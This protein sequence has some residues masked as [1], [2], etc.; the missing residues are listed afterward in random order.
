MYKYEWDIETGGYLLTTNVAGV[1]KELRPVF[2]EELNLLGF[3]D[4][5]WVYPESEKP[6]MWAETRRYIYR[7]ELVAEAVGGGLYTRPETKIYK[8]LTNIQ[9]VNIEEMVEKNRPLMTGLVQ[10]T[11]E[12]I[13]KTYNKYKNK[14]NVIYVAF[15]GG[16]DSL[17]LLDLVQK[18]LPHNEFKVIFGDTS[19]EISDTY[20][21]IDKVKERYSDLDIQTA[22]SHLDAKES[23][24]IFGPPSKTLRWCCAVH[25]S[26]P[27]LLKL[28]E[29]TELSRLK[30]LV[31]DGV[32]AE[33]SNARANYPIESDGTKHI[34]QINCSPILNWTT[35]ELFLYILD[36]KLML[37]DAYRY[38]SNRVG[39][40][41]CPMSSEWRDF[42]TN[43]VYKSDIV[44]FIDKIEHYSK[45]V[46]I[47]DRQ[48]KA[49]IESGGW[50]NRAG[51][52]GIE[53]VPR[54]IIQTNKNITRYIFNH[55]NNIWKEWI[56]TIGILTQDS[57]HKY[58]LEY[59]GRHYE[60][61]VFS[62]ENTIIEV[63]GS[64]NSYEDK[65]FNHCLRSIFNKAAYCIGCKVCMVECPIGALIITD[66][67]VKIT[68]ECTRCE[69]CLE[70]PR[71]CLLAKS[72][73]ITT[74]GTNMSN[75]KGIN[76]YG[77]FGFRKDWLKYLK[78][79]GDTAFWQS[80]KLGPD[81]FDGFRK[82]LID[83]ELCEGYSLNEFGKELIKKDLDNIEIW[84]VITVN[85]AY[86]SVIFN[87]YIS[88]IEFNI[89][90]KKNDYIDMLGDCDDRKKRTWSNALN[91]L[92]NTFVTSP[93]GKELGVGVCKIKG[94]IVDTITR[95]P[96]NNPSP[97]VILYSL[98][99]FA[100]KCDGYY[101]FTLSYLCD[102]SIE[103]NGISPST[104]F[105]IGKDIL[106]AKIQN[107][108]TDY[109]DF[110]SATFSKD[111]DNIDLN[112]EKTSLDVLKLF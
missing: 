48:L 13:Y 59:N 32:R 55:K 10:N 23:W 81:Q 6:L 92:L 8:T 9:P 2:H 103:R 11:V 42:I 58:L 14:V 80:G 78:E 104:I 45:N 50:R 69:K 41:L 105:G 85:L 63:V 49:Y 3:K 12:T 54:V 39:C 82:W 61:S 60:F 83:A 107:L 74:G 57:E 111:L 91:S 22:K 43:E 67:G 93:I 17:V 28:R 75:L 46:G 40:V 33:E 18:A 64:E 29:I 108:A 72:L 77:T 79:L 106:K 62:N 65:R 24:D 87:W 86:N 68:K 16:K 100:E 109:K 26:S 21:T 84:G 94:K 110:I 27:S 102:E 96:W 98:Y 56:R 101:S 34:T 36:V 76:R 73:C 47:E 97:L 95:V 5:G 37:N 25:K 71:G 30:A 99:K 19:M 88:N 1:S 112:K 31:F 52:R 51:G 66:E 89:S 7:G 53:S 20:K 90:Q 44:A 70:V 15:S 4:L 35:S 38:G